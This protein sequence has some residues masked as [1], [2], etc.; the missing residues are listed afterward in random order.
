MLF[1]FSFVSHCFSFLSTPSL[2]NYKKSVVG[3]LS[4]RGSDMVIG[5]SGRVLVQIGIN[6]VLGLHLGFNQNNFIF[7]WLTN[8]ATIDIFVWRTEVLKIAAL[9]KHLYLIFSNMMPVALLLLSVGIG[10]YF[11]SEIPSTPI[12]SM[13]SIL[14][15]QTQVAFFSDK[16]SW[17]FPSELWLLPTLNFQS[18]LEISHSLLYCKFLCVSHFLGAG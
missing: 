6:R 14:S 1:L 13:V 12:K 11:F 17:I 9:H 15:V 3:V 7:I 5:E 18:P 2:T 16:L 4:S 10:W 8:W